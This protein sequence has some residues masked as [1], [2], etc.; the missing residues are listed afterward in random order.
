[1]KKVVCVILVIAAVLIIGGIVYYIL[2]ENDVPEL[3]HTEEPVTPEPIQNGEIIQIP[4]EDVTGISP[5]EAV[6]LCYNVMGE[7]DEKTG[8]TFSFGTASAVERNKKQYYVI[9]ASWLVNNSHMSYIGD[10]FVAADGKEIYDGLALP[11]EY[12]MKSIIWSE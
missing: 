4:I 10:F 5:E 6:Q 8:F 11:D 12:I 9:R 1:M 2:P 7:K 3:V